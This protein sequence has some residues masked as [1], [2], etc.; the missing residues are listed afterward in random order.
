MDVKVAYDDCASRYLANG[1]HL[2]VRFTYRDIIELR[3][4]VTLIDQYHL[5]INMR[6]NELKD[7]GWLKGESRQL[8][9]DM[10]Q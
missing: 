3:R 5:S 4:V 1:S 10:R 7:V 6:A 9:Q 2:D 8:E